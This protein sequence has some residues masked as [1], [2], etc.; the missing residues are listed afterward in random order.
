MRTFSHIVCPAIVADIHLRGNTLCIATN[1]Q[2]FFPSPF[3]SLYRFSAISTCK[4]D[5]NGVRLQRRFIENDRQA[6]IEEASDASTPAAACM[7]RYLSG[8]ADTLAGAI[9][10]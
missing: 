3:P 1:H 4:N 7:I 10:Q 5:H 9:G 6:A 2:P 8:Q